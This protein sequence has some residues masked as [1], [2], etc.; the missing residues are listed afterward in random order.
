MA[1]AEGATVVS[2]ARRIVDSIMSGDGEGASQEPH[3]EVAAM[4]TRHGFEEEANALKQEEAIADAS[5]TA[6]L[7]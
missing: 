3:D 1:L 5:G 6:G 7:H 4:A 2:L